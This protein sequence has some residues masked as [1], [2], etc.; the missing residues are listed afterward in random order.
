MSFPDLT[1]RREPETKEKDW[2][3][4]SGSSLLLLSAPWNDRALVKV[5]GCSFGD[6]VGIAIELTYRVKSTVLNAQWLAHPHQH[7]AI[8]SILTP[9]EIVVPEIA[10]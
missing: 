6:G 7:D 9:F 4:I 5:L 8:G 2:T 10:E 1:G 3:E